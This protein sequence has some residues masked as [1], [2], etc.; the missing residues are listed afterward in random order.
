MDMVMSNG[1]MSKVRAAV[2]SGVSGDVFEIGFG[3]GLNLAH[4]PPHVKKLTTADPNAGMRSL[5]QK[6]IKKSGITVNHHTVS[7]EGLPLEDESFDC[8]VCTWTLCSIPN[9]EQALREMHRILRPHGKFFFVEHGLA[10]DERIRR[11]QHR[12]N[13]LNKII[14]DGCHL[15]RNMRELISSQRFKFEKIENYFLPRV[16]KISGYLYQGVATKA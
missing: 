14:G 9:V 6:R 4:Y 15:N 1:Q 7:G 11:W 5:A 12:L 10:E 16:P 8:V 3:T 13:P 2:L